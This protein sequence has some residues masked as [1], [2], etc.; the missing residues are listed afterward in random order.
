M[1]TNTGPLPGRFEVEQLSLRL[2]ERRAMLQV[3]TDQGP[4]ALHMNHS[5]LEEF[6]LA[7][8]LA[9]RR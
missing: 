3:E 1:G 4:L 9:L 6:V 5:V 2:D 7:A 8:N